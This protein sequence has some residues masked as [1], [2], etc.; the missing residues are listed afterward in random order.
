MSKTASNAPAGPGG[1]CFN[2]F[3]KVR[4]PLN[5]LLWRA[6]LV[7]PPLIWLFVDSPYA[8]PVRLGLSS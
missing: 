5:R 6:D 1:H 2:D 4:L 7:L 3:V 8:L